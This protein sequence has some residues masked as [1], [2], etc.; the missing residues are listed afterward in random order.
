MLLVTVVYFF[1]NEIYYTAILLSLAV[2]TLV[3]V[4]F[5]RA[6][7]T[8][9]KINFLGVAVIIS[10]KAYVDFSTSGL[11]NPLSHLLLAGFLVIY[12]RRQWIANNLFILSLLAAL[13]MVTRMDHFSL[14][15]PPLIYAAW[16]TRRTEKPLSV[17]AGFLPFLLW[18]FFSVVYYGFPFPNTAYAKLN[19]GISSVQLASHGLEYLTN[20]LALDPVTL[21]LIVLGGGV[22]LRSNDK[23]QYP[24]VAGIVLYIVYVVKVGGDFMGGRFLTAPFIY[25]FFLFFYNCHFRSNKRWFVAFAGVLATGLLGPYP[26]LLSGSDY[27]EN[28]PP[29]V[30]FD[31]RGF[32]YQSTGLLRALTS[33]TEFPDS[34]WAQR[35]REVRKYG[36]EAPYVKSDMARIREG[37]LV[38]QSHRKDLIIATWT[39]IGFSGFYGG[40]AIHI[41]DVMA[42]ADPLLARLPAKSDPKLFIGHF[43]RLLP[44]GYTDSYIHGENR[45]LDVNLAEY[46]NSLN[47]ITRGELFTVKRWQ[48]IWDVNTGRFD[49]TIDRA[50]YRNP[51]RLDT[52]LSRVRSRPYQPNGYLDLGQ[53]YFRLGKRK[54]AIVALDS[55]LSLNSWSFPNHYRAGKMFAVNNEK[56]SAKR[57]YQTAI[58]ISDWYLYK[59]LS[60]IR[61]YYNA[62]KSLAEALTYVGDRK[63]SIKVLTEIVTAMPEQEGLHITLGN[64]LHADG[65][66]NRAL[67]VYRQ[68]I[69]INPQNAALYSNAASVLF[70]LGRF[71]EA[72]REYL[73]AIELQPDKPYFYRN[74]AFLRNFEGDFIGASSALEQ[75]I[76]LEDQNIHTHLAL[77]KMYLKASNQKK[78]MTIF[79]S[80]LQL[81]APQ[82][83]SSVYAHLGSIFNSEGYRDEAN[84]AYEKASKANPGDTVSRADLDIVQIVSFE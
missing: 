71:E 48:A 63:G 16:K 40:P 22:A 75:V 32:F 58:D 73:K 20:S 17:I 62:K 79:R 4:I 57:A 3:L 2:S 47:V 36:T 18:E 42:L 8:S 21:P 37:F 82:A 30:P 66:H 59:M 51:P 72:E 50:Y 74:L 12:L 11:E 24:V 27:A 56:E 76:R 9:L 55:A 53:E 52:L 60:D 14:F 5:F 33:E 81:E 31:S 26:S 34:Q 1:T 77:G 44:E 38:E 69:E 80:L 7:S 45:L 64:Q 23:K 28:R 19:T 39:N 78:A 15:L 65:Q 6:L 10:S 43:E 13:G 35:G 84:L 29:H 41:V 46:F 70:V 61:S 54:E 25:A 67:D 68:G 83:D 49:H